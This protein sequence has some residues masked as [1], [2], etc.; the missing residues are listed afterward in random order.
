MTKYIENV[1][2]YL[3]QMKIKQTF[4]SL[5]SGI[6]TKKLSRLLKGNQEISGID[7]EKIAN[8]LGKRV[9]F[10]LADEFTVPRVEVFASTQVVFCAGTPSREQQEF[11]M[12]LIELIENAD[13]ILSAKGR[14]MM[15]T[16]E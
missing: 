15:E 14:Y 7:M 11:A 3:S 10:F 6:D 2:T 12:Q 8:A 4:V 5:R 16:G 1:N 9:E 13:E